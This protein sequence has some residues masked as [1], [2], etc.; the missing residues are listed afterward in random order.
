MLQSTSTDG[1]LTVQNPD[2]GKKLGSL[3]R[4]S[5]DRTKQEAKTLIN[6]CGGSQ[7]GRFVNLHNSLKLQ[8]S[9]KKTQK[10]NNF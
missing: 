2:A 5:A 3:H 10:T 7:N 1:S 8:N 9:Q 6:L 4:P